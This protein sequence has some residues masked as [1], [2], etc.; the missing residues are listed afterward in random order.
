[1]RTSATQ[2][3]MGPNL[4]LIALLSTS[5]VL[6]TTGS[7][8]ST[9]CKAWKAKMVNI[10]TLVL[11]LAWI[12]L[13]QIFKNGKPRWWMF[14]DTPS[15]LSW[16]G[17]FLVDILFVTL[18]RLTSTPKCALIRQQGLQS[19]P[20]NWILLDQDNSK[21]EYWLCFFPPTIELD[22]RLLAKVSTKKDFLLKHVAGLEK[23]IC[24]IIAKR[25]VGCWVTF[26]IAQTTG[27]LRIADVSATE[28]IQ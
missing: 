5:L 21:Y 19:R 17:A 18:T 14:L 15:V 27:R 20:T 16:S 28:E 10:A 2:K 26:T 4:G 7:L 9:M 11:K 12:F 3:G 24:P 23:A 22:Q 6:K 1:M 13:L 8:K 25:L